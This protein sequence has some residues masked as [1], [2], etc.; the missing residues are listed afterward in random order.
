M[1]LNDES[2]HRETTPGLFVQGAQNQMLDGDELR[3]HAPPDGL[4]GEKPRSFEG[5]TTNAAFT[6]ATRH[7][8][9]VMRLERSDNGT[10]VAWWKFV[11]VDA[12]ELHGRGAVVALYPSSPVIRHP[13]ERSLAKRSGYQACRERAIQAG[14]A[15]TRTSRYG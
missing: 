8:K 9:Y 12:E 13:V 1:H 2:G 11:Q 10:N 14:M 4:R 3:F 15:L 7:H 5:P 6:I